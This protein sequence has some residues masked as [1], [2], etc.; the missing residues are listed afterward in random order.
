M[1]ISFHCP[2]CNLAIK[3]PDDIAGKVLRCKECNSW[4]A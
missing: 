2:E 3:A 1:P 4:P